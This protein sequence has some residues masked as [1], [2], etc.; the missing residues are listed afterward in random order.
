MGL[1]GNKEAKNA[2]RAAAQGELDRLMALQPEALALEVLP[3]LGA[4]KQQ[5]KARNKVQSICKEL[6]SFSLSVN[7]LQLLVPV[8]EALQRLQNSNLVTMSHDPQGSTLWDISSTGEQA[9]ADGT[10]AQKLGLA[11][12]D[13]E[14]ILASVGQP[15]AVRLQQ[16]DALRYQ[17]LVSD[18]QFEAAKAKILGPA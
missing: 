12:V 13:L 8:K 6:G 15:A 14:T 10:A 17:R 5:R 18:E 9:L 16:L 1:F 11:G 7:Y 2:G 3:A 4:L